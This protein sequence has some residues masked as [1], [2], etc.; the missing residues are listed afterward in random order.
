MPVRFG[1]V[2]LQHFK[3]FTSSPL[4]LFPS[5]GRSMKILRSKG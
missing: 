5:A 3:H 2:Q 1:Y 4:Y